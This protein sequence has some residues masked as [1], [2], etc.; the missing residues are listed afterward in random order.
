MFRNSWRVLRASLGQGSS[1]RSSSF[2]R[3][4]GSSHVFSEVGASGVV[5]LSWD[6]EDSGMME[7]MRFA[8]ELKKG[9]RASSF[10]F[11]LV[12]EMS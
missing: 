3:Q 6:S 8:T 11:S 7:F 5:S 9:L 12:I 1:L 10:W 2:E 4:V